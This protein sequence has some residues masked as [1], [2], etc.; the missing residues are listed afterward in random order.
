MWGRNI[1]RRRNREGERRDREENLVEVSGVAGRVE[2]KS[3]GREEV[4]RREIR[5]G[6]GRQ[7]EITTVCVCV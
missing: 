2:E 4:G 6:V 5:A 1:D 7:G 3:E